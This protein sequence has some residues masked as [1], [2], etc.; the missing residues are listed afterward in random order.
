MVLSEGG[1]SGELSFNLLG[2]F[3]MFRGD[4]MVALRGRKARGLLAYLASVPEPVIGRERA[5]DLLWSDRGVEQARNSLRQ[6]LAEIRAT[7]PDCEDLLVERDRIRFARGV[8]R[9]DMRAILDARAALDA[10]ALAQKLEHAG[11]TFLA[12]LSGLS[13][14]FDEWLQVER[15]AQTERLVGAVLDGCADMM[16]EARPSDIQTIL[17]GLDRIDPWNEAVT[18]L[19]LQADFAAGDMAALHRRY[20]RLAD[21][22]QREFDVAPSDETRTLFDRLS[23]SAFASPPAVRSVDAPARPAVEPS[24]PPTVLVSPIE[25]LTTSAEAVEIAAIV[26][27]DIRTALAKHSDL[28]VLALDS[29]SVE[30]IEHFC[31]NSVG[32]YMVSGRIRQLGEE[33][34][35]NLTIGRADTGL[36]IWSHQFRLDRNDLAATIDQLV[37]RAAG[38]TA[39][40]VDHDLAGGGEDQETND[41]VRRYLLARRRIGRGRDLASIRRGV[42][43]LEALILEDPLHVNARLLLARMYNT[44]FWQR[45]SG[46]DVQAFRTRAM[47]LATEA[48]AIEPGNVRLQLRM[49]WCHLRARKWLRAAHYFRSALD[50]APYDAD[51]LNEI[52][53]GLCHLGELDEAEP[54]MQRAVLLNPFAPPDYLADHA[55]LLA[56]RGDAAAA[57]ESFAVSGE[58]GP[59]YLA[60]R[61][62]NGHGLGAGNEKLQARLAEKFQAKFVES[63]QPERKPGIGDVLEWLRNVMP[64]KQEEHV[65]FFETGL[66]GALARVFPA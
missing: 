27:D 17:R 6:T 30:R 32:T 64:L 46:H 38:A 36:V 12:D 10:P 49:A 42:E 58:E 60:V 25:S 7:I 61:L 24:T 53:F 2:E 57:E 63:W 28:R 31:R 35:V 37:A 56:L 29:I 23:R 50:A 1:R 21:A 18:R 11:D 54:V 66:A 43:M 15:S 14:A 52:G 59:T 65:R 48:L 44:D 33:V 62:A 13:P 51:A 47:E 26:T 9:T 41:A 40:V 8:P 5:A 19:G 20:R 3:Q 22:L 45:L 55:V 4:A 34:R 16:A 39:P